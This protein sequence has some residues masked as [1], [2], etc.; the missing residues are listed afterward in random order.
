MAQ[1]Q[2]TF[3]TVF[4]FLDTDKYCSPFDMLVAIDAFPDSMIFKFENVTGEDAPKIVYDL[5][6]KMH[7]KSFMTCFFQE[8][9]K[10]QNTQ[11]SSLTAAILKK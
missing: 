8:D 9:Q 1:P 7:Q 2:P 10:E 4:V 11:R 6:A 3:K 5:L